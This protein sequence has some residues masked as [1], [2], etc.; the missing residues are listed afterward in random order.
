M[1]RLRGMPWLDEA[2]A[3]GRGALFRVNLDITAGRNPSA[4]EADQAR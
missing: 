1:T 4:A 2:A 3:E